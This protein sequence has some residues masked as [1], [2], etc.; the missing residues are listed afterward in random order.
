MKRTIAGIVAAL[1]LTA[2]AQAEEL[3][4]GAA[5]PITGPQAYFGTT[6]QN[7]MRMYFDEVNA[8]GGINGNT[9]V[10]HGEDDKADPREGTLVA[11]KFCDDD[12]IVAVLAHFNSGVALPALPIY[13]DCGMPQINIASNPAI[14]QQGFEHIVRP[15]ANDFAQAGFPAQYARETLKA[16]KAAVVHD[17][18][19]FGQGVAEIFSDNFTKAGG[20]VTSTSSVNPTD[21]DFTALITQLK[22]QQ[23][24]VV[25]LGAVMPQLALFAKQMKEQGLNARL[26]VPDGGYTPDL[27][28]QAGKDAAQGVL[29]S[30]QV[31]PMDSTEAL[32]KFAADYKAK[33]GQDVGAYSVYGYVAAQVLGEAVKLAEEPTREG[34]LAVLHDVKFDSALGPIEFTPEGELTTAPIFLYEVKDDGFVLAGKSGS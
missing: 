20:T 18:Q 31:P 27:I 3:G 11:Q 13:S 7:G 21:V 26:I 9:F 6:L 19:A 4:V 14:T 5:A 33:F 28:S 10:F 2:G 23:P 12:S 25:Y 22:G 34:I 17:K 1:L 16:E 29:V 30:F 8:A 15:I 32:K 24:D